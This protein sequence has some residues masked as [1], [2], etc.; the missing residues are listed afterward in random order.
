MNIHTVECFII[1]WL[2]TKFQ[3]DVST[4][5]QPKANLKNTL[6]MH[7]V[8]KEKNPASFYPEK[9]KRQHTTWYFQLTLYMFLQS[10]DLLEI[11]EIFPTC[12]LNLYESIWNVRKNRVNKFFSLVI[13]TDVNI[14]KSWN[15]KHKKIHK[16]HKTS[17]WGLHKRRR[18]S[19]GLSRKLI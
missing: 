16:P 12:C 10:H 1:I 8:T 19:S 18:D 17:L 13:S 15:N 2:K 6:D 4:T 11:N 14:T 3:Y 7:Y 5:Q 9:L